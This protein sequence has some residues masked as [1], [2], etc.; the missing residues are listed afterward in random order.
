MTTHVQKIYTVWIGFLVHLWKYHTEIQKNVLKNVYKIKLVT[1]MV[2]RYAENDQILLS[3][4]VR[5]M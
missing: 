2:A 1:S 3:V 5:T 4:K